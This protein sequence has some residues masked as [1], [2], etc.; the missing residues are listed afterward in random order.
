MTINYFGRGREDQNSSFSCFLGANSGGFFLGWN[1]GREVLLVVSAQIC[2]LPNRGLR[3][4]LIFSGTVHGHSN[5]KDLNSPENVI[6]KI[7]L[8]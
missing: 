5:F 3:L 7:I 8:I 4:K 6:I 1:S 2:Y